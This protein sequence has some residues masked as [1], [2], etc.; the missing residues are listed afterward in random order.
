MQGSGTAMT[1][2]QH[3]CAVA[4]SD[5][6]LWEMTA[7]FITEGLEQGERVFYAEDGTAER[8]LARLVDD[9]VRTAEPLRSG[10]LLIA[11]ARA[12]RAALSLPVAAFQRRLLAAVDGALS[13]GYPGIRLIGQVKW[14]VREDGGVGLADYELALG[15][16][17]AHRPQAR[18]LCLYDLQR[19]PASLVATLERMHEHETGTRGLYDDGLLRVTQIGPSTMRLAGEADHSNHGILHRLLHAALDRA[20][21]APA[22]PAAVTFDVSSVRFLSVGA[23]TTLVRAA[24]EF[25]ATHRLVLR[26]VRNRVRRVLDLCGADAVPQ[27]DLLGHP[28]HPPPVEPVVARSPARRSLSP[29]RRGRSH[30]A[31]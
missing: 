6:H 1:R 9:G 17:L 2:A 20:L 25:P 26:G 12:T 29:L 5:E 3:A 4:V 27:L 18:A 7:R 19:F 8:V 16:V 10:Q 22:S 31:A 13:A 24:E 30:P 28:A 23:A 15:R 11:P 14:A 21:R